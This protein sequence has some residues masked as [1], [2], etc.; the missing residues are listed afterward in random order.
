MRCLEVAESR[1]GDGDRLL[2]PVLRLLSDTQTSR[3]VHSLCTFH[4]IR[5]CP[6]DEYHTPQMSLLSAEEAGGRIS[7]ETSPT[8]TALSTNSTA[9]NTRH[10]VI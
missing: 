9:P 4:F 10:A 5:L 2:E 7:E 3:A 6:V 1:H 8:V